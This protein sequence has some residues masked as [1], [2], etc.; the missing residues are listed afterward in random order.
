MSIKITA[1][2]QVLSFF[3]KD[4]LYRYMCRNVHSS[5]AMVHM[6]DRLAAWPNWSFLFSIS[7][8]ETMPRIP[9]NFRNSASR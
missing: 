8:A 7:R 9:G 1:C 3:E 6:A 5:T 4:V 2:F